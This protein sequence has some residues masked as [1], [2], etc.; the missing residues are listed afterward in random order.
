MKL[1]PLYA[2]GSGVAIAAAAVWVGMGQPGLPGLF[3]PAQ[4]AVPASEMPKPAVGIIRAKSFPVDK[5]DLFAGRFTA[6]AHVAIQPQ[7]SG[8]LEAVHFK[9]GQ[10]VQ[11]G[12]LLFTIDPRPFAAALA[13]AEARLTEARA[14]LRLAETELA[15]QETLT[16]RGH[17][18]LSKLDVARETAEAARATISGAEA[19]VEQARLNL[20]YTRIESPISGRIS[21]EAVNPGNLLTVGAGAVPLTTIVSIDPIHFEFDATE[22]QFLDYQNLNPNKDARAA[23]EGKPV[24]VQLAG[25][26]GFPHAGQIDFLDNSLDPATGTIRGRAVLD[27]A[28]G[29]LTPGMFGRLRMAKAEA[30]E[31]ILIPEHAIGSDQ[32]Q[33]FVWVIA[34]DGTA[35]RRIVQLGALHDGRRAVSGLEDGE[36]VAVDSLHM[37]S[38]GAVFATRPAGSDHQTASLN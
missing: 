22:Q 4:A 15:R 33:K 17:A 35:S 25:E 29:A 5:Y 21:D 27:N 28:D 34:Q 6:A 18:A 23:T 1:K 38:A 19:A 11:K 32:A 13:Q 16:S 2:A 24:A 8:R 30:V 14:A 26:N 12:D 10:I 3:A 9:P 37:M 36:M 31:T 20:E 7:V